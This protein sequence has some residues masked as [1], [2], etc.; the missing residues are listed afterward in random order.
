M[1]AIDRRIAAE[2]MEWIGTPFI[3]GQAVKGR[4]CDCKGLLRGVMRELGRAEAESFYAE[5]RNYRVD[6]PVPSALLL[7]GFE[8]LFVRADD[9]VAGRILL[10]NYYGAPAHMAIH[11]GGGRAVH[12][13]HG[14]SRKVRDRDLAVLF[15]TFPLHSVWKV[16]AR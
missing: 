13:Y 16:K 15:H 3:W 2:A 5:F 9:L 6:R 7:E 10:L 11:V 12:A 8:K 4:G 1:R 14:H